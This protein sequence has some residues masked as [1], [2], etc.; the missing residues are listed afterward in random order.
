VPKVG[1]G[2]GGGVAIRVAAIDPRVKAVIS[3]VP[4]ISG[5]MD[6]QFYPPGLLE[7]S[8]AAVTEFSE[9]S[10]RKQEYIQIFPAT[11]EEATENPQRALL[12]GPALFEFHEFLQTITA[13]KEINWENKVTLESAFYNY[14]NEFQAYLPRVS[15][16]PLLYIAPSGA[17]PAEP[18][19]RAYGAAQ[20]PKEFYKIEPFDFAGYMYGTAEKSQKD[21]EVRFLQKHLM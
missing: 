17:L 1:G 5:A 11:A 6:A 2:H 13:G 18:H 10:T 21:V 12:G 20:E 15:P 3:Q 14:V 7:R 16:T 19:E 9:N 8:R 4:G